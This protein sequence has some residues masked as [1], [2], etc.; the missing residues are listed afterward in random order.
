MNA[1]HCQSLQHSGQSQLT[2]LSENGFDLACLRLAGWFDTIRLHFEKRS[3]VD[4]LS[5]LSIAR[6]RDAGLDDPQR[7]MTLFDRN[8]ETDA[9]LRKMKLGQYQMR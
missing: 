6:I 9:S 8:F 1:Q 7:Q 5:S 2:S 4:Y 3:T